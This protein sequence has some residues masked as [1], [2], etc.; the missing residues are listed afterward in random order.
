MCSRFRGWSFFF[1]GLAISAA[2]CPM[3]SAR[4]AQVPISV[5]GFDQ[6]MVV[7]VGETYA[8]G[9]LTATMDDGAPA[10]GL[11]SIWYGLGQNTVAPTTGLPIG[12]T[13]SIGDP[14]TTFELAP[15]G[16]GN[17]PSDDAVLIDSKHTTGG[18]TLPSPAA[19]SSLALFAASAGTGN[20]GDPMEYSLNFSDGSTQTGSLTVNDWFTNTNSSTTS[21]ETVAYGA[22]GRI[23]QTGGYYNVTSP[24]NNPSLY[25]LSIPVTSTMALLDSVSFTYSSGSGHTAILAISGAALVPEPCFVALMGLGGLGL[26]AQLI[27]RRWHKQRHR[28]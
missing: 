11:G 17:I 26:G 28:V 5:T 15:F 8:G 24:G 1:A 19:Y 2:I 9:A 12:V 16:S 23:V 13:T 14:T 4:G 6:S 10:V 21:V 25:E 20:V 18:L 3:E 27:R 7:A 22:G